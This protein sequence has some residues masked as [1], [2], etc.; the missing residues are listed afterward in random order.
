MHY[1]NFFQK[2]RNPK[3]KA[4]RWSLFMK[5]MDGHLLEQKIIMIW[6][7]FQVSIITTQ[8]HNDYFRLTL[9]RVCK[10]RRSQGRN[11]NITWIKQVK[12]IM[13]IDCGHKG[14]WFQKIRNPFISM[15]LATVKCQRFSLKPKCIYTIPFLFE[16]KPGSVTRYL[17]TLWSLKHLLLK[18]VSNRLFPFFLIFL[19][20]SQLIFSFQY[21]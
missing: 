1:H 12:N 8:N 13:I 20:D 6:H 5:L 19:N 18:D 14:T 2:T 3:S 11:H 9:K 7:I 10:E 15:S 17:A 21:S 4:L 16:L